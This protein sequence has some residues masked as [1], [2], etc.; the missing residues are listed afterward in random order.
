[1][2]LAAL[3]IGI[4]CPDFRGAYE[5]HGTGKEYF[6]L[7]ITQDD[8]K[9]ATFTYKFP[10]GYEYVRALE[11][12]GISRVAFTADWERLTEAFAISA[13]EISKQGV[14]EDLEEGVKISQDG[15]I[16]KDAAGITEFTLNTFPDGKT[17]DEL[18]LA[19]P[20]RGL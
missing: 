11:F 19:T 7:D 16:R 18:V 12:D 6:A 9:R 4:A 2:I 20:R 10:G 17:T 5:W 3:L 15:W 1:L 8:C 14:Y 13:E